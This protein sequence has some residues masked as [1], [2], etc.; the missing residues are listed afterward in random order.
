MISLSSP[1]AWPVR[2]GTQIESG[3]RSGPNAPTVTLFC[4]RCHSEATHNE[5]LRIS[6]CPVHGL[7]SSLRPASRCQWRLP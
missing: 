7:G 5:V 1:T 4:D 6:F 3:G 2:S